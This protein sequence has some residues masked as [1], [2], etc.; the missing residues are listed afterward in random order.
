MRGESR[1]GQG[2]GQGA[3]TLAVSATSVPSSGHAFDEGEDCK[4]GGD[5]GGGDSHE[6]PEAV[7]Q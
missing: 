5:E 7:R 6:E 4:K 1:Q 3:S 2:Q